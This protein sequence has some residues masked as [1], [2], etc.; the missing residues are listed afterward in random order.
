MTNEYDIKSRI[1]K[2][3]SWSLT[4]SAINKIFNGICSVAVA[5]ILG[6]GSFGE[7]SIVRDT[8]STFST[9]GAFRLGNTA[10]KYISQHKED[11]PRKAVGILKLS[12][13]LAGFLC[14]GVSLLVFLAAEYISESIIKNSNLKLGLQIGSAFLFFNTY[15]SIIRQSLA[16]FENFKGIAQNMAFLSITMC[17]FCIPLA[18]FMGMEGALAGLAIASIFALPNLFWLL[19]NEIKKWAFPKGVTFRES[20]KEKSVLWRFALP[21]F[22]MLAMTTG[23]RWLG[24]VF[25]IAKCGA[26]EMGLFAAALQLVLIVYFV[27]LMMARVM[28]PILSANSELDKISSFKYSFSVQVQ[29]AIFTTGPITILILG[30]SKWAAFIYG[31]DFIGM[32]TIMP[33]LLIG[34]FLGIFNETLRVVYE[35]RAKQWLHLIIYLVKSAV[36]VWTAYGLVGKYQGVG[37]GLA[38]VISEATFLLLSILM[39]QYFVAPGLLMPHLLGYLLMLSVV[40]LGLI[41]ASLPGFWPVPASVVLATIASCPLLNKAIKSGQIDKLVQLARRAWIIK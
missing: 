39:V 25:L 27:P 12:V 24:R 33:T 26:A 41:A 32:E 10:V 9:Y 36:F 16:G 14:A 30:L 20:L 28:L 37:L 17:L 31:K 19:N 34:G 3:L 29:S 1:F 13:I 21:G 18:Y 22:M 23:S 4:G 5:R 40:M 35:S 11:N 38:M 15:G 2:G 8:I 7:F 6:K